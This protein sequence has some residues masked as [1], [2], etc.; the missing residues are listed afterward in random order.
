[1]GLFHLG[2]FAARIMLIFE[3]IVK[4]NRISTGSL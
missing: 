4:Q 1:M 2:P 3:E